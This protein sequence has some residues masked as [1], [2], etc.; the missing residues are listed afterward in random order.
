MQEKGDD[1]KKW[2][3]SICLP[4][5]QASSFFGCRWMTTTFR[6]FSVVVSQPQQQRAGK[7]QNQEISSICSE[8]KEMLLIRRPRHR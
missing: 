4:C 5:L 2:K 7:T 1:K 3:R 6:Y 8:I